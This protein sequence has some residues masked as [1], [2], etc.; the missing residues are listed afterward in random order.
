MTVKSVVW[1]IVFVLVFISISGFS[2]TSTIHLTDSSVVTD[3]AGLPTLHFN[4]TSYSYIDDI[5]GIS[6]A[7]PSYTAVNVSHLNFTSANVSWISFIA[8]DL[9]SVNP[10]PYLTFNKSTGNYGTYDASISMSAIAN[11]SGSLL[12]AKAQVSVTVVPVPLNNTTTVTSSPKS[13][14]PS[15]TGS[16]LLFILVLLVAII[17]AVFMMAITAKRKIVEIKED[18]YEKEWLKEQ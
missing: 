8:P 13:L 10:P 3:T 6:Y 17:G 7:T 15:L 12:T 1:G 16:Q 11:D 14:V 2:Q 5:A 9:L 4:N 18:R